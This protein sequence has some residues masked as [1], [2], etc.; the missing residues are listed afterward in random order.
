MD[1]IFRVSVMSKA[2]VFLVV[3]H[4]EN[5]TALIPSLPTVA[6]PGMDCQTNDTS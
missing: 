4:G 3:A 5:I 2:L 1:F 6:I